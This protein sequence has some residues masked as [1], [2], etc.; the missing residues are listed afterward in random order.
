M[1]WDYSKIP[2]TFA[3]LTLVRF[4]GPPSP[5]I[6]GEET[7]RETERFNNQRQLSQ[8]NCIF[9][10]IFNL[11]TFKARFK[12]LAKLDNESHHVLLR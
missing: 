7:V 3:N 10:F 8:F 6:Q 12:Y 2:L 9:P 4:A 11:I 5:N 1:R